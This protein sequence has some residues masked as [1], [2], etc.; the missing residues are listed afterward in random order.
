MKF[1]TLLVLAGC[2]ASTF[3]SCDENPQAGGTSDDTHSDIRI[4]GRVFDQ[5]SKPL[6]SVIVRLRGTGLSDTTDGD[7]RF[8]VAGVVPDLATRASLSKDT[9]DYRRDGELVHSA[10][11][12]SWIE[13]LP[14]LFLVQRDISGSILTGAIPVASVRTILWN[15]RGDSLL[16]DAEWNALSGRYSGFSWSRYTG[17][18]DS[19]QVRAF[20]L[21]S[22]GRTIGAS[23]KLAFTSR[24]GD[25][26]IPSFVADNLVPVVSLSLPDTLVRGGSARV[27]ASFKG[28]PADGFASLWR[29]GSGPWTAGGPDTLLL[30][31]PDE[32]S[33]S[34]RIVFRAV[35]PDGIEVE[36]SVD[37]PV[38]GRGPMA[39]VEVLPD[40]V[41]TFHP[42]RV[43]FRDSTGS[44]ARIVLRR[45]GA[46][47]NRDISGNDTLLTAPAGI[48]RFPVP[49]LVV[50]DRGDTARDSVSLFATLSVPPGIRFAVDSEQVRLSWE[51][52]PGLPGDELVTVHLVDST[53]GMMSAF[54]VA[55]G[56]WDFWEE[57]PLD[58]LGWTA[59]R[60]SAAK[61][62]SATVRIA[63]VV[64]L[65]DQFVELAAETTLTVE[66]PP[67]HWTFGA[68]FYFSKDE[69]HGNK[70]PFYAP[71]NFPTLGSTEL[72]SDPEMGSSAIR[73]EYV[74]RA[75]YGQVWMF[76]SG[77]RD[78]S[79]LS[80]R[81]HGSAQSVWLR[82][83]PRGQSTLPFP[84]Y[85]SL[86]AANITLG[87]RFAVEP[88]VRTIRLSADSLVWSDGVRRARPSIRDVLDRAT[89]AHFHTGSSP[90]TLVLDD[91]RFENR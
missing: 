85:D 22:L 68:P 30:L 77:W 35:R 31:A 38:R 4:S 23:V 11:V 89:M 50:D 33:R 83:D 46:P 78:L 61:R 21:D 67:L 71:E 8:L 43:S 60:Q 26:Q 54:Y 57:V 79:T 36:A 82:L 5:G 34:L 55:G 59:N 15:A 45:L 69:A 65:E 47:W 6:G 20:A 27:V 76:A 74:S 72:V 3:V 42:F 49:Y 18:L 84:E 44:G 28:A 64:F 17:G 63:K 19:F 14:D 25:V 86:R 9:L 41:R 91:V 10:V 52:H 75:S 88:N 81:C 53:P 13:T 32:P 51:R 48:G 66:A 62:L 56:G 37:R 7:G 16:L 24:A 73:I 1:P 87:W 29:I 2:L 12:A 80:F 90:G 40:T 39:R 58:S 70:P